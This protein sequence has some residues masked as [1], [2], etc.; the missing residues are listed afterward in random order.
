MYW[1]STRLLGMFVSMQDFNKIICEKCGGDKIVLVEYP[2]EH[3][4]RYDGI[5]EI[6]CMTCAKR[7]GR[8]S[9]KELGPDEYEKRRS[10]RKNIIGF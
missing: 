7:V 3:P 1:T 4:E 2:P 10:P 6:V 5:S 9:G 8:W